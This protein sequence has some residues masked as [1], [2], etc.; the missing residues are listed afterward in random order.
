MEK[1]QNN[2]LTEGLIDFEYK[3][4][5]LLAYF[6]RV[7]DSFNRVELYPFLSDLVF[8]YRNLLQLRDN[9]S[10]LRDSFPKEI[11]PEGLRNLELNYKRMIEDDAVMQE[12]E[13]I[14]EFA[15]PQFKSS[16]DEGA[17]IYDYVESRCEILP[18]G[19]TSLYANEG[20][21]FVSQPPEDETNVYRYQVTFFEQSS[22]PMRGI[23]TQYLLTAPRSISNTYEHIKLT[24][25]RQYAELP[26]PSVYLVLSKLKFP[27]E[28][29]L[30]PVA[31]RL[32]VKQISKAA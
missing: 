23:H 26:N 25:I 14:M 10:L 16:L 6:K 3:K 15:L 4:Y 8:H 21:L 31:R 11:S 12:L 9:H 18:V 22:E 20:Y 13:S 17:F 5:Q 29:T 30:M 7:K 28:K 32:L 19:L 2:W 27:Y 24:L 1:L